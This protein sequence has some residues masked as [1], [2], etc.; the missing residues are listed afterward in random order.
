MRLIDRLLSIVYDPRG[1]R[2]EAQMSRLE[3]THMKI[4]RLE[5]TQRRAVQQ[6]RETQKFVVEHR[7]DWQ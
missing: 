1:E 6:I 4:L 2:G 3:S 7:G 5:A